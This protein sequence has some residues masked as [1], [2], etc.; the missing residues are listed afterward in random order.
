MGMGFKGQ[1]HKGN[2][3]KSQNGET[4]LESE[5]VFG[6]SRTTKLSLRGGSSIASLHTPVLHPLLASPL[7]ALHPPLTPAFLLACENVPQA[8]FVNPS[9]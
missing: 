5:E 9:K 6:E 3:Q 2:F 8:A 1:N 7:P 4:Q